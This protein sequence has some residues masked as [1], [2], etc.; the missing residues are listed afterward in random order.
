MIGRNFLRCSSEPKCKSGMMNMVLRP[1][2][3]AQ[4]GETFEISSRAMHIMVRLPFGPPYCSGTQSC[5]SP[6][7]PNSFTSSVG[8]RSVS[9]ISAAIG[10]TCLATIFRMLSRNA[11]CSSVKLMRILG[12]VL[13]SRKARK[14]ASIEWVIHLIIID[15]ATKSRPQKPGRPRPASFDRRDRAA[16]HR[17]AGVPAVP[18]F[19][20]IH[21][22]RAFEEICERIREQLALG[23]LKPG[24]KLPPERDLAQQLGASRNVL[25]EA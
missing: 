1:A 6:I 14:G 22:R 19:R 10:A 17:A 20:P 2:M 12:G 8:K 16:D 25:R 5:I 24:D 13:F 7:S 15:M 23:V 4:A 3:E 18:S 11:I 9:S 21:T